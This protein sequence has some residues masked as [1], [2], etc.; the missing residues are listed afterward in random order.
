MA[1]ALKKCRIWRSYG[2]FSRASDCLACWELIDLFG[3]HVI[4]FAPQMLDFIQAPIE[5]VLSGVGWLYWACRLFA[6]I[7]RLQGRDHIKQAGN[8]GQSCVKYRA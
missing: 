8:K 5:M 6:S 3:G 4:P 2:P 7:T 1:A